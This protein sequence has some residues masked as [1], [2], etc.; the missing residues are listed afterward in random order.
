MKI[1]R[2]TS[3]N[4]ICLWQGIATFI[5][6]R[7]APLQNHIFLENASATTRN[8]SRKCLSMDDRVSFKRIIEFNMK[9]SEGEG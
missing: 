2:I 6:I 3:H 7:S 9:P 8:R 5:T 1:F 4:N